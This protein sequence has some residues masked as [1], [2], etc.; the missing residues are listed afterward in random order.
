MDSKRGVEAMRTE[1]KAEPNWAGPRMP[2]DTTEP[3]SHRQWEAVGIVEHV[4]H[5]SEF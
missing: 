4:S 1:V 5:V 2:G 3:S